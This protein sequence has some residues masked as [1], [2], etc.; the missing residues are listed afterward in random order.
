MLTDIIYSAENE[1]M[2]YYCSVTFYNILEGTVYLNE[3][4]FPSDPNSHS[5]TPCPS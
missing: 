4:K 2:F 1:A 3:I 5:A